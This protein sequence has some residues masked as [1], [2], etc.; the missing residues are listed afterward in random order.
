MG[1]WIS[2]QGFKTDVITV[3]EGQNLQTLKTEIGH[4]Q[5]H[6]KEG[7]A[8]PYQ[9]VQADTTWELQMMQKTQILAFRDSNNYA[10][11]HVLL[12]DGI[13]QLAADSHAFWKFRL[14]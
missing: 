11:G 4:T 7:H 1:K 2:L 3:G 12:D 9:P 8:I 6:L 10:E 13:S 14:A 5:V